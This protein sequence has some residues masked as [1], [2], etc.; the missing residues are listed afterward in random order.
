MWK[1]VLPFNAF[2]ESIF[3][4]PELVS[5][6]RNMTAVELFQAP[7]LVAEGGSQALALADALLR[8]IYC[9]VYVVL[10]LEF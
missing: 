5:V 1:G 9:I 7:A 8:S 4:P 6:E 3:I 2:S 10:F